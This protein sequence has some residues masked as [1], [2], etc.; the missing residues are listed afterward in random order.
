MVCVLCSGHTLLKR[1]D[2]I[3][4]RFLRPQGQCASVTLPPLADMGT[5][6]S[7]QKARTSSRNLFKKIVYRVSKGVII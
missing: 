3:Q 4:F 5:T 2:N 1:T 6:V 7:L